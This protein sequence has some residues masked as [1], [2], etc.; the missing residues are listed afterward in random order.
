MIITNLGINAAS[1][2]Q[3]AHVDG[4]RGLMFGEGA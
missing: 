4:F 2:G 3:K 1:C